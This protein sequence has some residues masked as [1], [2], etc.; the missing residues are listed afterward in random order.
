VGFGKGKGK[1]YSGVPA[2]GDIAVIV[3]GVIS[4]DEFG[5]ANRRRLEG[6]E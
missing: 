4:V 5:A 6:L 1:A 3:F 2:H